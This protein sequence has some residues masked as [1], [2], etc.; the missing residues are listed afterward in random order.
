MQAIEKAMKHS[1]DVVDARYELPL[2]LPAQTHDNR[3]RKSLVGLNESANQKKMGV[4]RIEGSS[5]PQ[6]EL[7]GFIVESSW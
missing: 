1:R 4:S 7:N 6:I 2:R 3:Q 5:R